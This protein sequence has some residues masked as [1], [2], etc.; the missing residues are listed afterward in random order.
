MISKTAIEAAKAHARAEY[1]REMCGFIRGDEFTPVRNRCPDPA[2][3][4][5]G[6]PACA[7]QLCAFLITAEDM[8]ANADAE[9]VIHSHPDGPMYPSQADMEG[10]IADGRPWGIISLNEE[11]I[12]DPMFWGDSLPVAPIVGRQFMHGIYDCYSL[13]RDVFRLGRDELLK[14]DITEWPF[15]PIT[16]PEQPR[17]D[18]WWNKGQDFYNLDAFRHGFVEIRREEARP[19]DAFLCKINS[20]K[21]NHGGLL[22]GNGLILHHLPARLSRREPAGLWARQAGRWLRYVGEG[23]HA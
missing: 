19:G 1:P 17:D 11:R 7:C 2:T 4:D 12:S 13:V 20:Q 3:H 16:L 22:I 6:D 23:G 14:Q 15:D 10:Q 18:A 5:A 8:L 9:V 21:F